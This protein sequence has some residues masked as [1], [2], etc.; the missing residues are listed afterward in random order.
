MKIY[1]AYD[2]GKPVLKGTAKDIAKNLDIPS[3]STVCIYAKK[4]RVYFKRYT[5]EE[6]GEECFAL[7][8]RNMNKK[9]EPTKH[10]SDLEYLKISLLKYGNSSHST[11]GSQFVQELARCGIRFTA[12][13]LEKKHYLFK[14]V[15]PLVL[16][17]EGV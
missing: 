7:D 15:Y 1:K 5:F 13:K 14:R 11:N 4:K 10:E 6:T 3:T 8:F 2:N 12:E 9:H 17:K 16:Y